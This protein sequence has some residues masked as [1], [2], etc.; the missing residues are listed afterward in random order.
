M[1]TYS[2]QFEIPNENLEQIKHRVKAWLSSYAHPDYFLEVISE[3][4]VKVSKVKHD[5]K[6]CAYGCV[7]FF[8]A[9]FVGSF[10]LIA[11]FY[12]GGDI[13]MIFIYLFLV[14]MTMPFFTG[15]FCLHPNKIEFEVIFSNE[16]P[17]RVSV[18]ASGNLLAAYQQDYYS[19]LKALNPSQE[20]GGIDLA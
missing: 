8:L 4:H 11:S 12:R 10:I 1:V 13:S 14:M 9:A 20:S 15:W 7:T 5:T 16:Y 19:F 17:I 6:I 2:S 18:V 3:R